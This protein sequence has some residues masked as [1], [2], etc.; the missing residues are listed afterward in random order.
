MTHEET[1]LRT[2]KLLSESLKKLMKHKAFSKITIS[3]L[4]RDCNINRKTFYYHFEDI[5]GLLKWMLEQEAIEVVKNFDL[6]V[7]YQDAFLFVINYVEENSYFLNCIYDSV[8]RDELKRFFYMDFIGIVERMIR[9]T[10]SKMETTISDDFRFF[11]CN[12]YAEGI[13]GML[14]NLFQEPDKYNKKQSQEYF[15]I[16]IHNSIPAVIKAYK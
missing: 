11:L 16:V 2:K 13:A 1:S 15:G 12:L 3:E 14:I 6:L 8:G 10:E 7:D 5:F 9:T 4:I